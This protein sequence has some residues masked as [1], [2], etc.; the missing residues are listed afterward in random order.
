VDGERWELSSSEQQALGS[1]TTARSCS[2]KG[3]VLTHA[4]VAFT[5]R[6]PEQKAKQAALCGEI[7]CF[8]RSD[9]S[10]QP[11]QGELGSPPCPAQAAASPLCGGLGPAASLV[12]VCFAVLERCKI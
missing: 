11:V 5:A 3:Q 2:E 7:E 8:L 4:C 9:A 10:P 1:R 12:Q 6:E